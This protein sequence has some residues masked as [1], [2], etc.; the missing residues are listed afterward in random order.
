MAL[1]RIEEAQKGGEG[2][3]L[4]TWRAAVLHAGL[5]ELAR[6]NP[7][8]KELYLALAILPKGLAFP[9]EVAGVLLYGD[10]CSEEDLGAAKRVLE[11]LERW[12]I[13]TVEGGGKYRV[14]DKHADFIQIRLLK[15]RAFGIERCL[16]GEG[17]SRALT[18]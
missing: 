16:G 4:L 17:T 7:Q 5:E 1:E 3:K 9:S 14:H 11:T 2:G 12:S 8:N 15:P 18:L 6:D 10:G 13:F